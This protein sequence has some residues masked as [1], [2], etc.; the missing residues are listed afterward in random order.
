MFLGPFESFPGA[1]YVILSLFVLR[2]DHP[3]SGT[4]GWVLTL[5]TIE[6]RLSQNSQIVVMGKPLPTWS[7]PF[8][9]LLIGYVILPGTSIIGH[10]L[11][12]LTGFIFA[13]GKVNFLLLPLNVLNFVE[14]RLKAVFDLLP[15]YISAATATESA[16][17]PLF[18]TLPMT[19]PVA[20]GQPGPAYR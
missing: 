4:F 9:L 10:S 18:M 15:N 14:S 6:S 11:G 19:E 3:I 8:I 2:T 13:T 20:N 17:D 5:A 16:A 12:I 1:L 7:V